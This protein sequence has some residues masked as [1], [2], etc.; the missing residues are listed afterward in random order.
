MILSATVSAISRYPLGVTVIART[1]MHS[2][3]VEVDGGVNESGLP[4]SDGAIIKPDQ[5]GAA[6][7]IWVT[8]CPN[9]ERTE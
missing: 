3:E 9:R 5:H 6:G 1:S 7:H 8:E 2:A 4:A